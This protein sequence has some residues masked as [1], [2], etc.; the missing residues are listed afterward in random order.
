MKKGI[1]A[2]FFYFHIKRKN[3]QNP[4]LISS[5]Q[6]VLHAYTEDLSSSERKGGTVPCKD[7]EDKPQTTVTSFLNQNSW[8]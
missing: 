4:S 7:N 1:C 5:G 8:F 2:C 3:P 6:A